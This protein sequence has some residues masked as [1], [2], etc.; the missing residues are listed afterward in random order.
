MSSSAVRGS[1]SRRST[2]VPSSSAEDL[3]TVA[4]RSA[5][6]VWRSSSCSRTSRS[7]T[8]SAA[9]PGRVL[10]WSSTVR[11]RPGTCRP[12]RMTLRPTPRGRRERAPRVSD[13]HGAISGG[14]SSNE[15]E[16]EHADEVAL[17]EIEQPF[18]ATCRR[19]SPGS[20]GATT[21]HSHQRLAPS[22]SRAEPDRGS[23]FGGVSPGGCGVRT[24]RAVAVHRAP[25]R[26]AT[27]RARRR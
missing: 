24:A 19:C 1:V 9:G 3:A 5:T 14:V 8:S 10:D 7:S 27:G 23:A 15:F 12:A 17:H 6:T 11:C 16:I 21:R 13:L 26:T 18:E 22:S 2:S 25:A 4:P 20:E